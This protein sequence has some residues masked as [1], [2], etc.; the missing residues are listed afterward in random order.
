MARKP[1]IQGVIDSLE[2]ALEE[3]EKIADANDDNDDAKQAALRAINEIRRGDYA[4]A[5]TTLEREFLPKW[6]STQQ[7]E[8]DLIRART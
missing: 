7:C 2:E 4:D 8:Q 5:I 1:T 6:Q 3:A